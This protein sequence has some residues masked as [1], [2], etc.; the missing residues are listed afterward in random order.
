MKLT[1]AAFLKYALIIGFLLLAYLMGNSRG[2]D[3]GLR[4][5]MEVEKAIRDLPR[6]E[7]SQPL[8]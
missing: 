8:Y 2:W 4:D 1:L 5:G 7:L 6:R 3:R